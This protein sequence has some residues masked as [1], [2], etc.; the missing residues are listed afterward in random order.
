MHVGVVRT[1]FA[2][3]EIN[4]TLFDRNQKGD[5]FSGRTGSRV[6]PMAEF[7]GWQRP[8]NLNKAGKLLFPSPYE[9]FSIRKFIAR[10]LSCHKKFPI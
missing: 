5:E 1:L 8:H 4:A 7:I 3:T 6:R 9:E 10:R 2:G